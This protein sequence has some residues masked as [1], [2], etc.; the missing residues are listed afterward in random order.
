MALRET[1]Q[2][3]ASVAQSL[4]IKRA[5]EAQAAFVRVLRGRPEAERVA[6]AEREARRLDQLEERIRGRDADDPD[7]MARRLGAL[8]Q[9]RQSLR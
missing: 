8:E 3:Y 7:K 2:S 9:L 6:L 4:G 1:G 5:T